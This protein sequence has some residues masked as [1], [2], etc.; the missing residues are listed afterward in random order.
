ML[1]FDLAQKSVSIP[2]AE[3]PRQIIDH[4]LVK[5][6]WEI[7]R[8]A[9]RN[10]DSQK[11][12][13]KFNSELG[14]NLITRFVRLLKQSNIPYLMSCLVEIRLREIRRSAIRALTRTYPRLRADP[15]R[16]NEQ[17]EVVERRMVLINTLDVLL[18]CEAQEEEESAFED[19][20]EVSRIRDQEAV[21]IVRRFELEVY[22][23]GSRPAGVLINLG[24]YFNGVWIS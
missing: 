9:Q 5:I 3:L 12:G 13:S 7:R 10:F 23:H 15:I 16:L 11:E 18:G 24:A 6:A 1:I 19:V 4:P 2:T 22:D 17:G 8:A 14:E 21:D 20:D